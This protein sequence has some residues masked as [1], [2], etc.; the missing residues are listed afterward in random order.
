MKS[1]YQLIKSENS[2]RA[3]EFLTL[4]GQVE[5]PVFLPVG[6]QATVKTLTPDEIKEIGFKM[7]LSNTYHLYLRPGISVLEK[8]G[9]LHRFMGWGGAILTDSGGY[10]VFSLSP[11][12][13]ISDEG[14]AFRSHID[15]STHLLTPELAVRYQ[16]IIGADVIMVLDE[17]TAT[18]ADYE[19]TEKAM[20][21]TH[22]WAKRCLD[23]RKRDDQSLYAIVQGGLFPELR[24]K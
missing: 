17:C 15:G 7:I 4:H 3:G 2:A 11:L 12:R 23:A 10:Q 14:V 18:D 1:S 8:I 9:G 16:E 13:Q 24:K 21:R 5:T 19:K 22:L 20:E 6:T